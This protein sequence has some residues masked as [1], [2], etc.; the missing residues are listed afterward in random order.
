MIIGVRETHGYARAG[1]DAIER[2]E[3]G[4]G[5]CPEQRQA[6]RLR[7]HEIRRQE[8]DPTTDRL[9]KEAVRLDVV[10]IALAAQRDP[11]AAIDEQSAGNGDG[12]PGTVPAARQRKSR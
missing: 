9:M 3:R 1:I 2:A 12:A 4:L 11:G 10:L 5:T 7:D 8:R 6:M